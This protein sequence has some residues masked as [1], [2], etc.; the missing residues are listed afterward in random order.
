MLREVTS[1]RADSSAG[2]AHIRAG[3]CTASKARLGTRPWEL[4]GPLLRGTHGTL[5][6]EEP[7]GINATFS[8]DPYPQGRA[9]RFPL[10]RGFILRLKVSAGEG[11]DIMMGVER[12]WHIHGL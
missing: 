7:K 12:A 5:G 3:A 8:F 6:N 10:G 2:L 11:E 9:W 1:S 4:Q